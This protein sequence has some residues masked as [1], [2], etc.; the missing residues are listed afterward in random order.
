MAAN[1]SLVF[2]IMG[3]RTTASPS[4]RMRTSLP[5]KRNSRGNRTAWLLP[6]LKSFAVFVMTI[7]PRKIVDFSIEYILNIYISSIFWIRFSAGAPI[8][9]RVT[10]RHTFS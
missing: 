2:L 10:M 8:Q 3:S 4:R 1:H 6:L 9:R 5:G 7:S